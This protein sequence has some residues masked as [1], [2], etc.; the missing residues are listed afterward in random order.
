MSHTGHIYFQFIGFSY[1]LRANTN[2]WIKTNNWIKNCWTCLNKTIPF[3]NWLYDE[4][5][6]KKWYIVRQLALLIAVKKLIYRIFIV[7]LPPIPSF[8]WQPAFFM[9]K[10]TK[11]IMLAKSFSVCKLYLFLRLLTNSLWNSRLLHC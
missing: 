2:K 10:P 7:L 6:L 4:G 3:Y 8:P 9:F 11:K 5:Y 1:F